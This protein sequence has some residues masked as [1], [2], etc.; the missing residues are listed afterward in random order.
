MKKSFLGDVR[1]LR[2]VSIDSDVII[3]VLALNFL[4]NKLELSHEEKQYL[5]RCVKS[6]ETLSLLFSVKIELIGSE[7]VKQELS[8]FS[9]LKELYEKV[10]DSTVNIDRKVKR[11]ARV[12]LKKKKLKL[13]DALILACVSR[14]KTDCFLSWDKEHM[15]N[16]NTAEI[17]KQVNK[18][19]NLPLPILLS[20]DEFLKRVTLSQE[21][22]LAFSPEPIPTKVTL[23]FSLSRLLL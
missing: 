22:T 5:E 1:K 16:N 18:S 13:A 6:L 2:R 11:L 14:S 17:V 3:D 15:I 20:P 4:K 23:K 12:Y 7:P 9:S 10:F 19:Q 8:Y 21:R